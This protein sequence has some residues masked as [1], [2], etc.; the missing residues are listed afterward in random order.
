MDVQCMEENVFE[1]IIANFT[2]LKKERQNPKGIHPNLFSPHA[3][4]IAANTHGDMNV[5]MISIS[6]T[7][8][9]FYL[10]TSLPPSHIL[11]ELILL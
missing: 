8:T 1:E 6:Q 9:I 5:S 11:N 3:Q 10:T 4:R 7:I 2:C